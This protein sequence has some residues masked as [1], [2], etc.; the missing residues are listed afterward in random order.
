[1]TEEA[2]IHHAARA[3]LTAAT[4]TSTSTTTVVVAASST[5]G[6][7]APSVVPTRDIA[8]TALVKETA[9]EG[10]P[11]EGTVAVPEDPATARSLAT[12]PEAAKKNGKEDDGKCWWWHLTLLDSGEFA[13]VV[14][15]SLFLAECSALRL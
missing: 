7:R 10:A 9:P 13:G 2:Q 3:A 11:E 6:E 8:W 1:M 15:S 5:S 14:F 4:M 12:F